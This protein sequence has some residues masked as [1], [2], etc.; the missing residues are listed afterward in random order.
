MSVTLTCDKCGSAIDILP[1]QNAHGAECLVC[2][3][4]IQL[5]FTANHEQ[6]E[7]KA[8]PRCQKKDFYAQKDFNRKLGV[9]LFVIAAIASIWTYGLSFVALYLLDVWLFKKLSRIAICYK[10]QSI[11]RHVSNIK[12]ITDF[13]HEMHDRITYAGHDFDGRPLKH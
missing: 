1:S 5:I 4:Y 8:C 9:C 6:G 7:L 11:F 3:N 12:K 13:N 10:C 2:Q